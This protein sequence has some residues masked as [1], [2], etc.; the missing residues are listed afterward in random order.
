MPKKDSWENFYSQIGSCDVYRDEK[1]IDNLLHDLSTM[2]IKNVQIMDGGT[3]VKLVLTFENDKQA[4]FKPMRFGRD[5]ETDPNHFYFGDFER[6]NAEI[7]TF[8][9]DK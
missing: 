1:V 3:Q 8:H 5:Y 4:V 6:H 2:K 9:L 7:A